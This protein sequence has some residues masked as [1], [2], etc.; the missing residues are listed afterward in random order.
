MKRKLLAL[1]T[2]ILVCMSFLVACSAP[3]PAEPAEQPTESASEATSESAESGSINEGMEVMGDNLKYDPTVPVNN[4]EPIEIDMWSWQLFD[5]YQGL[6]DRYTAIHP[7]VTINLIEQPWDDYF[8]KLPLALD[9]DEAPGLFAVHESYH[10]NLINYMAPLEMSLDE[11]RADFDGIDGKLIDGELYYMD[12]AMM[13]AVLFYNTDMFEAAGLTEEDIPT[14]WDEVIDVAKKLT[15]RDENGELVQAG[16]NW[17]YSGHQILMG[18]NYQLGQNM[19]NEDK[20][21]VS[22]NNPAFNEMLQYFVDLYRVHEVG[23]ED[24][25]EADFMSLGEGRTAMVIGWGWIGGTLDYSY[26]DLNW[27][28]A[29]IPLWTEDPYALGRYGGQNSF[30]IGKNASPEVQAVAQDIMRF[31]LVDDEFQIDY[32]IGANSFPTKKSLADN[33]ELLAHPTLAALAGKVDQYVNPG[34]F[35][36]TYEN[37]LKVAVENVIYNDMAIDE[38]LQQAEEAINADL[39]TIDFT[40]IE[41]QYVPQ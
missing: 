14:T 36:A 7:N 9:T 30:G 1:L 35:P 22:L 12:Y 26:P 27:S 17:N 10:D 24:F 33:E 18:L 19:F 37:N 20:Q 32:A 31:S 25:G 2:A 34:M 38:A 3:E 6:I 8:T 15:I 40:S 23:D 11:L 13:T 39:E 5:A 4:G 16:F 21:T 28:S 41:D 29:Q